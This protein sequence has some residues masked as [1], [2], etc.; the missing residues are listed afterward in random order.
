VKSNGATYRLVGFDTP[1]RGDRALCDK[2]REQAET[3]SARLSAL[4]SSGEVRLRQVACACTAGTEGSRFCNFG[5]SCAY[6]SVDGKD[7]GETLISE[8]LARP[9]VC[10]QTNCPSRNL[11]ANCP[12]KLLCA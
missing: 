10:G 3:A 5:R 6:L 8:R 11:G 9:F 12:A 2:E 1:E 7:V 4:V